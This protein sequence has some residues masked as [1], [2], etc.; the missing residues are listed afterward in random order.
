VTLINHTLEAERL[1]VESLEKILDEVCRWA[2]S[3][4]PEGFVLTQPSL[5]VACPSLKRWRLD[6]QEAESRRQ[7]TEACLTVAEAERLVIL[8][9]LK[10]INEKL[11]R[12]KPAAPPA[13]KVSFPPHVTTPPWMQPFVPAAVPN[14][15]LCV[16]DESGALPYYLCE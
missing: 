7:A 12:L 2:V 15:P 10:A 4:T 13:Q 11:A 14:G 3:V 8:E 1:K 16:I 9:S 5:F 6:R